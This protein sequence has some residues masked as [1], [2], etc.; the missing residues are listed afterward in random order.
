MIIKPE[1]IFNIFSM[2][3]KFIKCCLK[4]LRGTFC[5]YSFNIF[6]SNLQVG[7][8][9]MC[10]KDTC[11]SCK[12]PARDCVQNSSVN[13]LIHK[14]SFYN[15]LLMW[16]LCSDTHSCR[17]RSF[18]ESASWNLSA[19]LYP[20]SLSPSGFYEIAYSEPRG[21]LSGTQQGP[22][23]SSNDNILLFVWHNEWALR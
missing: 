1:I 17:S 8:W 2:L 23:G 7:G 15:Q 3:L 14:G 19:L 6:L 13:H 16:C 20:T 11:L 22:M 10:M 4:Y 5:R 21:Q 9:S 18:W 12:N